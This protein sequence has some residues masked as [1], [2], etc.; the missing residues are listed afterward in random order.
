MIEL[1]NVTLFQLNCLDPEMGVRALKYS[2]RHIKFA[3]TVLMSHERPPNMPD[4]IDFYQIEKLDHIGTSKVHFGKD[5][6]IYNC[7]DTEYY[8]SIHTDGYIINPHRWTDEFLNYDY[9][10]AP[11]PKFEWNAKNR[12]GNGGFRLESRKLLEVC[13]ELTWTHGHDDVLISNTFKELFELRGCK[14]APLEVAA[15]FSMEIPIDEVPYNLDNCFGY[16]GKWTEQSR[17]Y[18]EVVKTYDWDIENGN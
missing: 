9:I 5:S 10:G 14:F 12:V 7:I 16:H 6:P 8:L 1:K 18:S 4:D 15:K 13:S 3:R 11:W 2:S 17:Y